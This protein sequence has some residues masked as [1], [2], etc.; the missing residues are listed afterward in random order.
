[1]TAAS[2]QTL[3]SVV[4]D[5]RGTIAIPPKNLWMLAMYQEI[6]M[7]T[8]SV[9]HTAQ[10]AQYFK[11]CTAPSRL[12]INYLAIYINV[13]SDQVWLVFLLCHRTTT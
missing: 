6:V 2:L 4:I 11:L 13:Y 1:M 8:Q 12:R 5:S 10:D 9:Y 7:C 3:A